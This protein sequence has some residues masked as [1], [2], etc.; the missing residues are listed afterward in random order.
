MLDVLRDLAEQGDSATGAYEDFYQHELEEA[1]NM[2]EGM[3]YDEAH[4]A[5]LEELGHSP[6]G[7]YSKEVV[8]QFPELFNS[9]WRNFWG[10]R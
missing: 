9:N 5:A 2:A 10:I 8:E 4:Q 7:L 1:A 3:G 6:F